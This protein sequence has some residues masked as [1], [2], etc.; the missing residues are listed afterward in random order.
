MLGEINPGYGAMLRIFVTK[1]PI[2]TS[3]LWQPCFTW[4]NVGAIQGKHMWNYSNWAPSPCSSRPN[5]TNKIW[6]VFVNLKLS[7]MKVS[8]HVVFHTPPP[9][10]T[11]APNFFFQLV[12]MWFHIHTCSPKGI[13]AC[14]LTPPCQLLRS[15]CCENGTFFTK[16]KGEFPRILFQ[17]SNAHA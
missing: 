17:W 3:N 11:S 15:W 8:K 16:L 7:W 14:I 2:F 12:L 1:F 10:P 9:A 5:S 6:H 13:E 4:L